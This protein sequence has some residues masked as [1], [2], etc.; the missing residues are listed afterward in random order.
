MGGCME[1]RDGEAVN[2]IARKL[3]LWWLHRKANSALIFKRPAQAVAAYREMTA[4]EPGN[5]F[6][7]IMLGNLLSDMGDHAGAAAELKRLTEIS[8]K[9]GDA[10]FN[11]GYLYDKTDQIEEAERCFRRAVELKPT[12]DRA[13]YGLGLV[14]IRD[15]RL[16]A[17]VE[18]LKQNIK[19]QPFSP[20]GYY[21]LG[22]TL[23]HLGRT[24]E[25]WKVHGQLAGFEPKFSATLKR[26]IE[27]TPSRSLSRPND[28]SLP[29]EETTADAA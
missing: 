14:L 10:W 29:K 4:I 7:R 2:A 19:L 21:Q 20:Y 15:G 16:D 5:E 24:E 11:L 13:W 25:A 3:S 27:Q 28:N 6:A 9:N 23:H 26:D 1:Q 8:P 18:A 12:L 17:A 22:M